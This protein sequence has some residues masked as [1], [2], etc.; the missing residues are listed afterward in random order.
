M[1]FGSV[2]FTQGA[3][4]WRGYAWAF[5]SILG[6]IAGWLGFLVAAAAYWVVCS[7]A[8]VLLWCCGFWSIQAWCRWRLGEGRQKNEENN[9]HLFG[10][11]EEKDPLWEVARNLAKALNYALPEMRVSGHFNVAPLLKM[12]TGLS[13]DDIAAQ[14][15]ALQ[16]SSP[17]APTKRGVSG[18][19]G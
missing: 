8:S 11:G 1:L 15:K 18:V 2:S 19:S 5:T 17:K 4:S 3:G 6:K 7:V 14:V 9:G 16:R 13:M 12:T 10:E